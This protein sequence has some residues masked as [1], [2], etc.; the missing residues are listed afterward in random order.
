MVLPHINISFDTLCQQHLDIARCSNQ[1]AAHLVIA[2]ECC[3]T[4]VH[5]AEIM[6]VTETVQR[7]FRQTHVCAYLGALLLPGL[8]HV[9][10]A[11]NI[12][13]CICIQFIPPA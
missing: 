13:L 1:S 12:I 2:Y 4:N 10:A 3:Y 11:I 7:R 6:V 9:Q 8:I 5:H